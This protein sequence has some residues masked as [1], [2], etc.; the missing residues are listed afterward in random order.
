MSHVHSLVN[1]PLTSHPFP[2][3]STGLKSL[4]HTA[5]S[6]LLSILHMLVYM[7]QCYSLNS[8]HPFLPPLCQ[9]VCSLCLHLYCCPTN[10]FIRLFSR[11]RNAKWL[12]EKAL[13]TAEK[14]RKAKDKGEKERYTYLNAAFQ[15][16]AR[17]D[18]KAFLSEQCKEIE[19][20]N[21]MGKTRDLLKE[22][23]DIK[24]TF[25]AK[26]KGSK[27]DRNGIDLTEAEDTKR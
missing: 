6:H 15:R 7:F 22:I 12:S 5:N 13:Q 27:K 25:H 17:R 4:C 9:Q 23:G 16:T 14:R 18:K 20:E 24:E 8:S 11:K 1:L 10:I 19:E 21:K 3:Q 26:M 2:P